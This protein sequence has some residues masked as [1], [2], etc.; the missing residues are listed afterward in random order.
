LNPVH[1]ST[2][3][4]YDATSVGPIAPWRGAFVPEWNLG[5]TNDH[6]LIK[7]TSIVIADTKTG[8]TRFY[9]FFGKDLTASADDVFS[10]YEIQGTANAQES[11]VA[12]QIIAA[13]NVLTLGIGQTQ[14]TASFWSQPIT[15]GRWY[16]IEV[17]TTIQTGGT[18]TSV[19]FVDGSQ[20][21]SVTT[22][23]NTAAARGVLG[24]QDT[25]STTTG[26]IF[27]DAFVF[28]SNTNHASGSRIGFQHDRYP[29]TVLITKSTHLGLGTTELL[30]VTLIPGNGTNNVLTIY[31]TDTADVTDDTN[32][33]AIIQNHTALEPSIDLADLP[34]LVKRGAFIQLTGTLPRALVHVGASQGWGSHGRIR[35]HGYKRSPHNIATQ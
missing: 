2:L 20:V 34:C 12:A 9:V 4:R 23:T 26:H 19:L 1:Y 17:V 24:T 27:M 13:T 7:A 15:R 30:N 22:I 10:L 28:D 35:Q 29:E 8:W 33:V 18:G 25:L 11:V 14:A 21:A 16:C 6:T 31:D 5:D 3:A 32:V